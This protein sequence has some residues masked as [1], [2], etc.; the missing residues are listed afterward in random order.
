MDQISENNSSHEKNPSWYMEIFPAGT[1]DGFYHKFGYHAASFV[2][3][4]AQ[5]LVVSFDNLSDAGYPYPDIEPWAGKF[6]REQGWS[7][8]G[9]YSRGPSWYRD[10][11]LIDFLQ[12]LRAQGFFKRFDKV[13]MIGTSMGGF[14]ALTFSALSPGAIVAALS[15][16]TN[17]APKNVPWEQRFRKAQNQDWTL[18]FSDAAEHTRAAS[19]V[20]T[21]YDPFLIPDKKHVMRLPQDNVTHLKAFGFGHKSAV[22]LR[23]MDLLKSMMS[24]MITGSLT[25]E[26]FYKDI[27]DR[28]TVYMYRKSMEDHLSTRGKEHRIPDFVSAFRRNQKKNPVEP[29]IGR[30][31]PVNQ[32]N[33]VVSVITP[34]AETNSI[35][36]DRPDLPQSPQGPGNI[37]MAEHTSDSLR[38]MSDRYRREIMGFEE[39]RDVTLAQTPTV[40]IGML[41]FGSM[42]PIERHT[43]ED[44]AFHVVDE[45]LQGQRPSLTAQTMGVIQESYKRHAARPY[46][47]IV[48]LSETQA[49]MTLSEAQEDQDLFGALLRRVD[50]AKDALENWGKTLFVDRVAMRLL[51]GA[52]KTSEH[53]AQAHYANVAQ[54]L[55]TQICKTTGQSSFPHIIVN[56][57]S[58]TRTDGTSEIILA[59]G[60]LERDMPRANFIIPTPLYPYA[61]RPQTQSALIPAD[62]LRVDELAV[63]AITTIQ[64]GQPWTCPY[65]RVAN[66]KGTKIIVDF[67]SYTKLQL[68]DGPHGFSLSGC[69]NDV[70]ITSAQCLGTKV[71]LHCN[72]PPVGVSLMLNYAWGTIA[73][74]REDRTAN[75][76][77]LREVWQANS[78]LSP[79]EVLY[80]YALAGRVK[81]LKDQ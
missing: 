35:I 46:R 70:E 8:L 13:A 57:N 43:P 60:R 28:K 56:Q 20:Y 27:R 21:L 12:N 54:A 38:Y 68:D 6:I 1:Q 29:I 48:A 61:L 49:S 80:R 42:S 2:D 72:K 51:A 23:R 7:H 32:K 69:E 10:P 67:T 62:Q 18:P 71:I 14:A 66:C 9:I 64:R 41:D 45:T 50:E 65:M 58:G 79:G 5:Q 63:L 36:A 52:P 16:Q 37:W 55:R 17:L 3:R 4:G 78:I 22:V 74:G 39:R 24:G 53:D 19:K 81:I 59:E 15:P 30:T 31:E 73:D 47:T 44:F 33:D 40:A 25:T 11:K 34:P 75:R 77:N 26:Q 76:G